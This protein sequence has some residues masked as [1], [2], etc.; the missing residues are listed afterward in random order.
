MPAYWF[1][2]TSKWPVRPNGLE[3]AWNGVFLV[4]AIG[5]AAAALW[6]MVRHN[7]VL[8]LVVL[9]L[10]GAMFGA[11]FLA[12]FEVRYFF[13]LK[14]LGWTALP[15]LACVIRC[16]RQQRCATLVMSEETR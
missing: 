8:G 16:S 15:L 12:H 3:Y 4:A 10:M 14:A 6:L 11:P 13:P 5:S 9:L 7:F 1:S 2:A